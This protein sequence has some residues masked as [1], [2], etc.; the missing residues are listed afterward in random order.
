MQEL[1]FISFLEF[2]HPVSSL[3]QH[4]VAA[5]ELL[6]LQSLDIRRQVVNAQFYARF[7]T[8]RFE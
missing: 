7:I 6:R 1:R 3:R 4:A 5:D 2:L 8:Q